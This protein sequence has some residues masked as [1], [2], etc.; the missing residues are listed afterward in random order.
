MTILRVR[1]SARALVAAVLVMGGFALAPP[2]VAASTATAL[3][4]LAIC[5]P[6]SIGHVPAPGVGKSS[7]ITVPGAGSVTLLQVTTTTLKVTS[8]TPA[9][10]WKATI[11]TAT[12]TT[13]HVGFQMV[14]YD[15]EQ[16]RF[17]ARLNT[18]GTA[19]TT[20]VVTCT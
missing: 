3:P 13:V 19:I 20:T 15:N 6:K 5:G 12:G 11:L 4:A 7:T 17:W 16:A 1:R 2:P 9:S 8:A 18:T 14:K 10:G